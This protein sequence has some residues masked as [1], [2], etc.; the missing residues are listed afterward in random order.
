M[1]Y[2]ISLSGSDGCLWVVQAHNRG[3]L[4]DSSFIL[5]A[6]GGDLNL[7][8]AIQL[9]IK[10]RLAPWISMKICTC[11]F[12]ISSWLGMEHLPSSCYS[13]QSLASDSD[14]CFSVVDYLCYCCLSANPNYVEHKISLSRTHGYKRVNRAIHCANIPSQPDTWAFFQFFSA[15]SKLRSSDCS[16]LSIKGW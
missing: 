3:F 2:K 14:G 10:T 11:S 6:G 16:K 9:A 1:A 8:R 4:I 13:L 7:Y 5:A 15:I 12:I